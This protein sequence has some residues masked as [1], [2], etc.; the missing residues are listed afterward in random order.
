MEQSE[1][2]VQR[3]E[4]S[5]TKECKVTITGD[6]GISYICGIVSSLKKLGISS[7]KVTLRMT[8]IT[9]VDLS[10]V[11]VIRA[12]V[13]SLEAGGKTVTI[14][15][16]AAEEYMNLVKNAGFGNALQIS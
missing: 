5:K 15:F 13:K 16:Q 1:Y 7:Q 8:D 4:N 2:K 14:Q 6:M 9:N 3:R 10:S 12:F 11:Q